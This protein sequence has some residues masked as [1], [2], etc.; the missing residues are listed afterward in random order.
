MPHIYVCPNC[1]A[2][3][4]YHVNQ[5]A[6]WQN[7]APFRCQN[8]TTMLR[9]TVPWMSVG[10]MSI[11]S[12]LFIPIELLIVVFDDLLM[13]GSGLIGTVQKVFALTGVAAIFVWVMSQ[14]PGS[15]LIIHSDE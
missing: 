11:M 9:I 10:L 13:F 2:E 5:W 1:G 15:E 3:V 6:P 14:I 4:C 7:N 8:C 12:A